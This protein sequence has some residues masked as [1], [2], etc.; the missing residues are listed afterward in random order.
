MHVKVASVWCVGGGG[1]GGRWRWG[2]GAVKDMKI[3]DFQGALHFLIAV[4]AKETKIKHVVL[5]DGPLKLGRSVGLVF[6]LF[7]MTL[8]LLFRI[9]FSNKNK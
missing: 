8:L 5:A 7:A 9:R 6:L 1:G 2:R 4:R 3:A